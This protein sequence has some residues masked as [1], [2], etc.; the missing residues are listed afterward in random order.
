[1]APQPPTIPRPGSSPSSTGGGDGWLGT[2]TK[3]AG[4]LAGVVALVYLL[5][6]VVIALRLLMDGFSASGV[7]TLL[8]ELSREL[9]ISTAMIEVI[10][11]AAT[12]GL[13]AALGYGIFAP[14]RP[15]KLSKAAGADRLST[16]QLWLVLVGAFA[17][18]AVALLA[19][20]DT[21]VFFLL[22]VAIVVSTFVTF[23]LTVAGIRSIRAGVD[24]RRSLLARTG[25]FGAAFAGMALMPAVLLSAALLE[26]EE[27]QVCTTDSATRGDGILLGSVSDRVLVAV[28]VW[29]EESIVSYPTARVTKTEYGDLSTEFPCR[30]ESPE[31]A[32]DADAATAALGGHGSEVERKLA[33]RLR[34]WLQFDSAERWR[35]L[36]VEA[37]VEEEFE[38]GAG[39]G[40]CRRGESP[41]CDERLSEV[42]ELRRGAA[43]VDV[44]GDGRN[45][46]DFEAPEA[47]CAKPAAAVDCDDG[48][49]SAIYY[50]RTSHGNRWYWDYWWFYRY[51]DYT[52]RFN[53]CKYF[54]GDHEGDWEG[55]TVVTTASTDPEVLGAIYAAHSARIM[56]G[57]AA[58]PLVGKHPRAFVAEG[59]HATYPFACAEDCR[60]YSTL[61]LFK[62]KIGIYEESHDGLAG[63]SHN[64]DESCDEFGCVRP[65]P[66][67]GG[68]EEGDSPPIAGEWASWRGKWGATCHQGCDDVVPK[69][70]S[71]PR[72]PGDQNR[73]RCPWVPTVRAT[74]QVGGRGPLTTRPVGDRKR[75]LA[76]C[77]AQ[78]GGL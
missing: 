6:G 7:V 54:C 45:G 32:A 39:H 61:G 23:G 13:I 37:F 28:D 68:G 9:V 2:A 16:A 33:V 12:V 25:A 43:Y 69:R 71:S 22:I 15:K 35:P 41:P 42:D 74:P 64:S 21:E 30:P 56:V 51:S 57:P 19:A 27:V 11:P 4:L 77:E 73:F 75:L 59:T 52:G 70:G 50:R 44:H 34:P 29:G 3:V 17:L 72:S 26:F 46:N 53:E 78:R 8:A 65:L 31:A 24:G 18:S 67:G 76:A 36:A 55:M 58:L 66:E 20:L 62:A 47:E 60:Q 5:G 14:R 10:G 1:M 63:W 49:G 40:V 48:A 38:D